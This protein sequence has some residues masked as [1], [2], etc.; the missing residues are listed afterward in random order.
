MQGVK[1]MDEN[2]RVLDA[3]TL[4]D[5]T[6]GQGVTYSQ[7]AQETGLFVADLARIL[8]QLEL[9]GRVRQLAA[10]S[11]TVYGAAYDRERRLLKE[12]RD[13]T[14]DSIRALQHFSNLLLV[15]LRNS[16]RERK[17]GEF[18]AEYKRLVDAMGDGWADEA[19]CNLD[20]LAAVVRG[21][22]LPQEG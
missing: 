5:H 11:Y 15:W 21:E 18:D 20:H 12:W 16:A 10:Q 2:Q 6:D 1:A 4:L 13:Y 9:S 7:L 17:P 3:M 19:Y 22:G 8:T 14:Q